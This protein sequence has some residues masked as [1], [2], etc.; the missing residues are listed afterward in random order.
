MGPKN[1][2]ILTSK[3]LTSATALTQARHQPRS[4]CLAPAATARAALLFVLRSPSLCVLPAQLFEKEHNCDV[5]SLE[6]FLREEVG[7][8]NRQHVSGI[9]RAV[10][11]LHQG[12][13][14]ARGGAHS[15]VTI[16]VEGNISAGKS[17]FLQAVKQTEFGDKLRVVPEPVER[18][19]SVPEMVARGGGPG[20]GPGSAAEMQELLASA[21]G[22]A[23]DLPPGL[24]SAETADVVAARRELNILQKFY[25]D[26]PRWAYTFQ[27]W[28]FFTRFMQERDTNLAWNAALAATGHGGG[29][30]ASG[31]RR[32]GKRSSGDSE[33]AA[34]V[35]AAAAAAGGAAGGGAHHR[36]MER[37]VFSDRMVFVEA[38]KQ[39]N[40]L[41]DLEAAIYD[42]WFSFMLQDRPSLV[43]DAF[44]YLRATP[45]ICQ[46]RMKIRSRQEEAPIQIDYLNL[47]HD[48]HDNWFTI[49]K[50]QDASS[51]QGAQHSGSMNVGT[52][53]AVWT[54]KGQLTNW[55]GSSL[56][57][58]EYMKQDPQSWGEV[59]AAIRD[60][61]YGLLPAC[62]EGKVQ[63][64][65]LGQTTPGVKLPEHA[66]LRVPALVLDCDRADLVADEDAKKEYAE[67]VKQFYTYVEQ[68]KSQV[69]QPLRRVQGAGGLAAPGSGAT[70]TDGAG[71]ERMR[72]RIE[73]VCA[74]F[75]QLSEPRQGSSL[76]L[77][78]RREM[79][80][81]G[82]K[83]AMG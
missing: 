74:S 17:T 29:V 72:Q 41:T 61:T 39:K 25:E 28:V 70:P 57:M 43:P 54:T 13:E 21:A 16:C 58:K 45:E 5:T 69:W 18:W 11:Q 36:L 82:S 55:V 4:V 37:S 20:I 62:L 79:D 83:L 63:F 3:G 60:A 10:L 27:S 8:R 14:P 7:V 67:Y 2:Q 71:R 22:S 35:S 15:D 49:P 24:S 9:A 76:V 30:S 33:V 77:P 66:Q 31:R 64:L 12:L 53:D 1:A 23:S 32:G 48:K 40:T 78:T 44:I 34:A 50:A 47:L 56:R 38:L 80:T 46:Q 51:W 52:G 42:Q 26:S 81:L 6:H 19:T 68:L 73:K 65:D 75:G 59:N